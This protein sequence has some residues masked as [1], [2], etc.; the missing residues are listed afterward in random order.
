M[1]FRIL[2]TYSSPLG[3][4]PEIAEAVAAEL[5]SG[6]HAA[7]VAEMKDVLALEQYTAVV[8][9]VPVYTGFSGLGDIG[10][11]LQRFREQLLRMPVAIF[12]ISLLPAGTARNDEMILSKTKKAVAPV[13]PVASV[14][15]C[16]IL[17]TTKLSFWD[18]MMKGINEI[19]SG[20]FQDW[21]AIRAW[22]RALP[23]KLKS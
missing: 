5:R 12:V 19:P 6:G 13:T 10:N 21:D 20:Q 2:V 3:S 18:R 9:G 14:H 22:A 4:A 16:G 15:F 1:T 17:D 23:Q 8:I 7:D 11:F